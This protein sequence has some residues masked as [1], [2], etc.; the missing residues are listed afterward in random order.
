GFVLYGSLVLLPIWMQTLLGYPA[1]VAGIALAPRGLGSFLAMPIVGSLLSRLDPRKFLAL[2]LVVAAATLVQL[3]RLDL[4][5]GYWD[6]F[7]PQFVQGISLALL[8]VPLTTVSMGLIPK[9]QMGNATSIFNLLRNTGGSVGIATVTTLVSRY[10]QAHINTL[11]GHVTPYDGVSRGMLEGLT[12]GMMAQGSAP[13]VAAKQGYAAL[14]GMVL[15][16]ATILSFLDVFWLLGLIFLGLAPL[17]MLMR[18]PAK[19]G[20]SVA[21]H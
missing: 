5:A 10:S 13:A 8:F 19:G 7:W 9:E 17:V 6:F 16:Q 14:Y 15:R 1:V 4:N 20:G 2:G 3:G 21:A 11:V 12:Q 18:R